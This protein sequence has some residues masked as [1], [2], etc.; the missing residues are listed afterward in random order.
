MNIQCSLHCVYK[1]FPYSLFFAHLGTLELRELRRECLGSSVGFPVRG[2]RLGFKGKG[3]RVTREG[4]G[5]GV[6][7][8]EEGVGVL[9]KGLRIEY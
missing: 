4:V 9:G 1:Y 2:W 6:L 7:G 3:S 8:R 5:V